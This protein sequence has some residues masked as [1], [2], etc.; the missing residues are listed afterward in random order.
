MTA[1]NPVEQL[2][3]RLGNVRPCGDGF[4]ARCPAHDDRVN[5]L[6]VDAGDD[7]QALVHCHAGC[8][9]EKILAALDL[10]FADL[11][12]SKE[13]ARTEAPGPSVVVRRYDYVDEHGALLFQV[14]RLRPKKFWQ[15]R[16]D[17]AGG[18]VYS[19]AG[20]RRVLYRLPELMAA[21]PAE[22]ALVV[23]GEKDADRL[24]DLGFLATT[25]SQ[26]AGK[27]R[28]EYAGSLRGRVVVIVPDADEAGEAHAEDIAASVA[29]VA[30]EVRVLRLPGLPSKGDVS[31]WLD[32]GGT[33]DQLRQLVNESLPWTGVQDRR[34][35]QPSG[36]PPAEA[37]AGNGPRQPSQATALV[38]LVEEAEV[39]L[40]H[41]PNED[42]YAT[43]E[44]AGHRETW[45]VRAKGFRHWLGK[46]FFDAT[47]GAAG[48]QAVTDALNVLG[49]KAL[50]EGTCRPVSV[51][52]APHEGR[53]Y[54]DLG[55][56]RW[57]AVEITPSG[58]RVVESGEVPVRFRRPKSLLPLPE[59]EP[60]GSLAELAAFVNTDPDDPDALM[61]VLGWLVGCF[62]L[63]G[64]RPI[65]E[66]TGE[67]GTA[68]T[69]LARV[70]RRCLDP[71][72]APLRS[73]PR[74]ERDLVIAASNGAVVAF[75][76]LSDIKEWFSD[77]LCRLSTGGG[78]G[79]RELYTDLDEVVLDAQ[80]PCILTGINPVATRS[81][82]L[83]RTI[84]VVLKPIGAE[85]RRT[86]ADLWAS[87]EAAHPR[88]LGG[89]LDAVSA[90]LANRDMVDLHLKPRLADFVGFVE[91][92][93]PALGW[94]AGEFAAAFA[95]SR[96]SVDRVAIES[97]PIGPCIMLLMAE[98]ERVG[99]GEWRGTAS[100]LLHEL[101]R[102]ADDDTKRDRDWPK[103]AD[104]LSNHLRRLAPNLRQVGVRVGRDRLGPV[105]TRTVTLAL[106][107]P[108][109]GRQPR[110]R[111]PGAEGAAGHEPDAT[112]AT[113]AGARPLSQ[114]TVLGEAG[115]DR[116]TA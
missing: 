61:L 105:G 5:S 109:W 38:R 57:R 93:A 27:W 15:R 64:A 9:T 36:S 98:R 72:I 26:G 35:E 37:R 53:L 74:D 59:P 108:V 17:G 68:K 91:A 51:R 22:P 52:I 80:R 114:P 33:V 88:I 116:W 2:R 29:G 95:A 28:P 21:D 4:T 100:A 90:A 97:L 71:C 77:A 78:I 87:F 14:E 67:Q 6:K 113:D 92:A 12:P 11:F 82:L 30:A 19:L 1:T 44:V 41:D 69:T 25:A 75:D 48:G 106:D 104:R 107:E 18:W 24:V 49:G 8:P 73:A 111:V 32:A 7:G 58:W 110:Q 66:L 84:S 55:D 46:Q 42:A 60:G 86:E 34:T 101:G 115:F 76:N 70:L 31:D 85:A 45:P 102:F 83:D 79:G 43:V 47:G 56:S 13:A 112:D 16:P 94:E 40:F 99:E 89:L 103:R 20:V 96:K 81:D 65:L 3:A 54:L 10:S 62:S 63:D 39:E 50:Y 23:E